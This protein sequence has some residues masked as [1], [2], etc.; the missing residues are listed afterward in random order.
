MTITITKLEAEDLNR[1]EE[2]SFYT[3]SGAG[4]D[5]NDWV[6]GIQ[7]LLDEREIGTVRE[8][9]TCFGGD[10][11]RYAG[12][13]KDPFPADLVVL[14]FSLDGLDIGKLAMLKLQLQDRWFDDI[15]QNMR[16]HV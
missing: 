16:R 7:G 9:A 13:T 6:E 15:V 5:L 8:W 1:A 12:E 3:I 2:G 14:M 11:N 10:V 4:G